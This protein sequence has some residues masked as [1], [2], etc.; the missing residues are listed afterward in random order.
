MAN[1]VLYGFIDLEDLFDDRVDEVGVQVVNDAIDATIAEHNRQMNALV[2]LF[3]EPTTEFKISYQSPTAARLQ[4][5]DE[6]GRA[7]PLR[8]AGK[9]DVAYPIQ[10]GGAA[11]GE[12]WL[13]SKKMTVAEANRVTNT[14]IM[15][16]RRW[17]RDHILAALFADG[18]GAAYAWQFGD[19][20]HGTLNV[21][22]L[23]DA[24]TVTYLIQE[25][26]DAGATDDHYLA[27][28]AAIADAT[29]PFEII[30]DELIEHPENSGAVVSLIPTGLVAA[31]K[32][33]NSFYPARDANIQEGSG[34][35][36]LVGNLGVETP[37]T[38]FGYHD[39]GVWLVEWKSLPADYIVSLCTGGD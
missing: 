25:G 29:D 33:L 26:A 30:Q 15:A 3:V 13:A 14:L 12:T 32:A 16:D 28:V 24:D 21:M 31:T 23:A 36:V 27:Q 18:N 6:F 11:W 35:S 9:Y 8:P 7:R 39:A 1:Q 19:E 34:T 5:V 22:G 20:E 37:G 4:P 17:V 2:D 38:L 10:M